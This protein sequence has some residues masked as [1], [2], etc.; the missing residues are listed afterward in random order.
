MITRC[1]TALAIVA[2]CMS[3]GTNSLINSGCMVSTSN[4]NFL[5]SYCIAFCLKICYSDLAPNFSGTVY[6]IGITISCM[7]LIA[8]PYITGIIIEEEASHKPAKIS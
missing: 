3:V 6:A 1:D 5:T 4:T 2:I 7:A 8:S